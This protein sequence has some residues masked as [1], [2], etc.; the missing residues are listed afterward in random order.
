MNDSDRQIEQAERQA[1]EVLTGLLGSA[2]DNVK[3]RAAATLL[4]CANRLRKRQ[5]L[6]PLTSMEIEGRRE[7]ILAA[8]RKLPPEKQ[9]EALAI[10]K[11]DTGS[12]A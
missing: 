5:D 6:P 7:R 4:T 1:I 2:S 11:K 3:W 8:L 12:N 9:A 10:L